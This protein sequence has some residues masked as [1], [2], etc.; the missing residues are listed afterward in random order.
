M[1]RSKHILIVGGGVIGLCIAYYAM[2]KGIQVT[3]VERGQ[4]DHD[5][6]SLGNAGMIVPKPFRP[7][8]R[9]RHGRLRT[10]DD[11]PT[12]QVRS[13]SARAS[14]GDLSSLGLALRPGRPTPATC[15]APRRCCATLTWPA[16]AAYEDLAERF[17][18][19]FGLTKRGLLMLCQT[20]HATARRGADWPQMARELGLPADVLT[21]RKPRE[22]DPGVRM[23]IAGAVHF[24]Q[25][26]HL[27]PQ[28]F[29][30]G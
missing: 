28:A 7:A 13:L 10:A 26:C 25:D 21:A 9:A 18:D 8:G 12:R 23:D 22:L 1:S 27:T 5:C 4:P 29:C 14:T 3:V 17:G 2:Q 20:E 6:C 11:C 30:P 24:P 16:A 19:V 15:R